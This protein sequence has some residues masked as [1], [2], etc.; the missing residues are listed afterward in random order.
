MSSG[1]S[2]LST[3]GNVVGQVLRSLLQGGSRSTP[4]SGGRSSTEPRTRAPGQ[5]T[6]SKP[7]H[8]RRADA[9]TDAV[10]D[11][12]RKARATELAKREQLAQG[13]RSPGQL[14]ASATFEVRPPASDALTVAYE[15]DKDGAPDSGEVVWTWIP[16]DERDGRGKDRPVLIIAKDAGGRFFAVRLT[17]KPH[18]GDRQYLEIG[19]GAWDSKGRS[20]WVDIEQIYSV[21]TDGMRRE[22]ATLDR[23]RY[24][25]VAA[26]LTQRYG[27]TSA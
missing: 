3:L 2:F 11:T 15:P 27:W 1:R 5:S 25:N 12:E 4:T 26:A 22:A 16:Y 6:T 24:A 14:G 23:G 13:E 19:P 9:G 18:D 10:T 17:S 8:G 20:S 7:D 21:H